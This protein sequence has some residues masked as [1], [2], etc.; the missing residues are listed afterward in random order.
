MS[1]E[2][3]VSRVG[4]S[5]STPMQGSVPSIGPR[6]RA[7]RK[8]R[9]LTLDALVKLTGLDKSFLSRL[10]RDL[11]SASVATLVRV[12]EA[13]GIR[14]GTLF[15]P[16]T[17]NLVR[18]ADAPLV[19]FGGVGVEERLLS[20]GLGGEVMVLESVIYPGGHGGDE[21]Y[22]LE[23]D[24]SFVTV[25]EGQLEFILED[26]HYFLGVG[27][28]MTASSRI[29]HNWRNPGRTPTRVIWVTSPHP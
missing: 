13:L 7:A 2:F 11:T 9:G 6:L 22:T 15:D 16:P 1:L 26:A 21:L 18:A 5:A 17:A 23:A 29:P 24:L 10:E 27:D 3:S 19:N 4:G 14:P 28:S 25:L 8:A 12:C 20:Q